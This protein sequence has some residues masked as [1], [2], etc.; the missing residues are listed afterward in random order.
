[1]NK[2]V[3]LF[4]VKTGILIDL[5]VT[6]GKVSLDNLWGRGVS[7]TVSVSGDLQPSL[8]TRGQCQRAGQPVGAVLRAVER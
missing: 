3:K 5:G 1:M 7:T 8:S 6:P 4:N 2:I